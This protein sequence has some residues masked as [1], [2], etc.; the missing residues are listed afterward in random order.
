MPLLEERGLI[1][2]SVARQTPKG[3]DSALTV[4]LKLT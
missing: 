4:A 3:T 2:P 1:A